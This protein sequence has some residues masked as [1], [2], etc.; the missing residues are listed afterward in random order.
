[1][2]YRDAIVFQWAKQGPS[3]EAAEAI[4]YEV[5]LVVEYLDG[6]EGGL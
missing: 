3:E 4:G 2:V 1:M 6:C 5:V